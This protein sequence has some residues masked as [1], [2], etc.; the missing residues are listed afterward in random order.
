MLSEKRSGLTSK[1]LWASRVPSRLKTG[2]RDLSPTHMS[3]L[4]HAKREEE[5]THV[6]ALVVAQVGEP[7]AITAEDGGAGHAVRRRQAHWHRGRGGGRGGLHITRQS[8]LN[9][10]SRW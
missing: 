10:A 3:M 2:E 6:E 4:C 8:I 7:G 9:E 1:P 5:W